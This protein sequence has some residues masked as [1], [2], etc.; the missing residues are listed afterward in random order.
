MERKVRLEENLKSVRSFRNG[1]PEFERV[2]PSLL[3][4]LPDLL[5]KLYSDCQTFAETEIKILLDRFEANYE[6]KSTVHNTEFDRSG[7]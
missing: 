6:L 2:L 4:T 3:L 7:L 1:F 5:A